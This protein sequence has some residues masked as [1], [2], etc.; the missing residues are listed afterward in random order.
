V[1]HA[2]RADG[3]RHRLRHR[4]QAPVLTTGSSPYRVKM[5][6]GRLWCGRPRRVAPHWR[7]I[8]LARH[9]AVRPPGQLPGGRLIIGSCPKKTPIEAWAGAVWSPALPATPTPPTPPGARPPARR[10]RHRPTTGTIAR[11]QAQHGVW[12]GNR[13]RCPGTIASRGV[14]CVADHPGASGP[15]PPV[16]CVL[17][18]HLSRRAARRASI[19]IRLTSLALCRNRCAGRSQ[20]PANQAGRAK[21]LG[22]SAILSCKESVSISYIKSPTC[23]T[24]TAGK[25][26]VRADRRRAV[27]QERQSRR[28]GLALFRRRRRGRPACLP[29]GRQHRSADRSGPASKAGAASATPHPRSRPPSWRAL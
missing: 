10:C 4:L 3:L 24:Q 7:A 23:A 26:E 6:G 16:A 22:S 12:R 1:G 2:G 18:P 15:P 17:R 27:P 8:P 13:I 28:I 5:P 25:A 19:A 20:S 9:A 21:W 29:S 11:W 14:R